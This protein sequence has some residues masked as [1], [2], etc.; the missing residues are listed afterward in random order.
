MRGAISVATTSTPVIADGKRWTVL[1]VHNVSDAIIYI[2]FTKET[3]AVTTANG[4]PIPVNESRT[5]VHG[6]EGHGPAVT[7]IHGASGSKEL[8]YAAS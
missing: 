8:R 5:F 2:Q 4:M 6:V 1:H 7:A 3:T